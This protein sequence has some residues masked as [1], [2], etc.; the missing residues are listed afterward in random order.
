MTG[1]VMIE[2]VSS[3][4]SICF[5]CICIF[6]CLILVVKNPRAKKTVSSHDICRLKGPVRGFEYSK[7]ADS[8]KYTCP[9]NYLKT[10]C[11]GGRLEN[12][13][14]V[15]KKSIPKAG[16]V[17]SPPIG[18]GIS[19]TQPQYSATTDYTKKCK[20]GEFIS[21]I[22]MF[23]GEWGDVTGLYSECMDSKTGAIR[24]LFDDK[25]DGILGKSNVKQNAFTK[26]RS[27]LNFGGSGGNNG[28]QFPVS[29]IQ[30]ATEGFNKVSALYRPDLLFN[31]QFNSND[32][33]KV[34]REPYSGF[35]VNNMDASAWTPTS[36][37]WFATMS[38]V[39][40]IGLYLKTLFT[41]L[42]N[43]IHRKNEQNRIK[44]SYGDLKN[45]LDALVLPKYKHQVS[46][47][48]CGDFWPNDLD[49][50]RDGSFNKN[51]GYY[52]GSTAPGE[53]GDE[54]GPKWVWDVTK[55]SWSCPDG[56]VITGLS[57]MH[58]KR[59]TNESIR[60]VRVHC[61]SPWAY[62]K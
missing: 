35:K 59:N 7:P 62:K 10:H 4:S 33:R 37:D 30:D 18:K 20:N 24:T 43:L 51:T 29:G 8:K 46:A 14:C 28:T 42:G 19:Q 48:C 58:H 5:L 11:R 3:S 1:H 54:N 53:I 27:V 38:G 36:A 13:A 23:R 39:G 60:G 12:L 52:T 34:Y 45:T 47:G 2:V 16:E 31:L 61:D 9:P 6:F 40:G 55:K 26:M 41:S 56:K 21:N 25:T 50:F 17:I 32:G 22:T 44:K 49:R 57:T 15:K